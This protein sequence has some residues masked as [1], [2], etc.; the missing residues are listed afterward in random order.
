MPDAHYV[1]FGETIFDATQVEAVSVWDSLS[2]TAGLNIRVYLRSG[3]ELGWAD[4]L[5]RAVKAY[6]DTYLK[7]E[8]A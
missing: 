8:N 4:D 5:A 3:C 7:V 2:R 1:K 6:L